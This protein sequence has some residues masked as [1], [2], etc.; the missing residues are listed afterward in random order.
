[1]RIILGKENNVRYWKKSNI[2]LAMSLNKNYSS[3]LKISILIS[4][5]VELTETKK[6]RCNEQYINI[7]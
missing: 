3:V 6:N 4:P 2:I 5:L 7:T 1:M